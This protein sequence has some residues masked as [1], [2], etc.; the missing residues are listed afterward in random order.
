MMEKHTEILI[1]EDND[2]HA[3]LIERNLRRAGIENP[4]RRFCDGK[5]ALDFFFDKKRKKRQD[6][7]ESY[8]LLLDLRMPKV[9]GV[10][11]LKRIKKSPHLCKI[12]VIILTTTDNPLEVDRC[13]ALGCN[14]YVKKPTDSASFVEAIKLI[15]RFLLVNEMPN[16]KH[17]VVV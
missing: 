7:Y 1:C 13:Y 14:D 6:C 5:E 3:T 16:L 4:I 11:V 10:E 15:G 8:I 17:E 9:D 2:G 12:P